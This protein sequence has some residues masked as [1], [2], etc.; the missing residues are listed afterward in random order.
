ML[1]LRIALLA[2]VLFVGAAALLVYQADDPDENV[3][4]IPTPPGAER[5]EP[6]ADPFAWSAE[7]SDE[8]TRRAAAGTSR[9]LYTRSPGGAAETAA[10]VA[11]FRE[12]VEAA[13]REAGV[14]PDLLE[15]LVFLESAG[16]PDVLAPGGIESAAGLTQILAET[17]QNLLDMDIDL[18]RSRSYTR[19]LETAQREA[20][21]PRIRALTRAR[22]RV[23]DRFDPAKALAGTARYLKLALAEF[24][25]RE[26]LALVSYHMGMGN[27]NNV[28]EAFG[29]GPRPYV[30]LYF[31]SNPRRHRAA[32]DLLVGF[33]DDSSNY[34]WKLLA[35]RDVM[36]AH[37]Q[38][39]EALRRTAAERVQDASGRGR[40]L[41]GAPRGDLGT[42]N[43]TPENTGLEVAPELELRDEAAAV[44]AYMGSE[45]RSILG[46][47][48]LRITS[49][50]DGG[51][52]FRVSRDYAS[53]RQAL[54]FQYVL[55]RLTVLDVIAWSRAE[56][57][58][59]VTAG[60]DADVLTPLL[61]RLG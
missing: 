37:R 54:A 46:S 58:I 40:L 11:R 13:A 53:E 3:Q 47:G 48:A 15:G 52:S 30:E 22:A 25:G 36:R 51:W 39:P 38:D 55:D 24:D 61:D 59:R 50:T 4:V 21:G 10:R 20:N 57:T 19:R 7:R 5:G 16:R 35:A 60:R 18:E 29:G 14:N 23:D 49:A 6:V 34:Y 45:V 33:G 9:V 2:A 17:G 31:D 42:L 1:R 12:P 44:A 41:A 27:L 26:D 8:L 28:L 32:H 56:R 43:A